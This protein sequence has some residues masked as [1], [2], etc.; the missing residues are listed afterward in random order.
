MHIVLIVFG[1]L[2]LPMQTHAQYD[3]R[4]DCGFQ[5]S[6]NRQ[7]GACSAEVD[8]REVENPSSAFNDFVLYFKSDTPQCSK[9]YYEVLPNYDLGEIQV[10]DGSHRDIISG[11]N[12]S[13]IPDI[14][15]KQ[16]VVCKDKKITSSSDE[17][18]TKVQMCARQRTQ[19][20]DAEE[21]RLREH[22]KF[23]S[24]AKSAKKGSIFPNFNKNFSLK[25]A[26]DRYREH[27]SGID[28]RPFKNHFFDTE[29]GIRE[30][31]VDQM[32][33]FVYVNWDA[34]KN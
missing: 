23:V 5:E 4:C 26:K 25:F 1:L 27:C 11:A 28:G 20:E 34:I 33:D 17:G 10:V 24:W 14:R 7:Y 9:I 31:S 32:R 16:C 18:P 22:R 8:V 29:A 2:M 30:M 21:L 3:P 6:E 15:I 13:S 12:Y 19:I